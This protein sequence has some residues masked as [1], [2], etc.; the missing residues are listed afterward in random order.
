[1]EGAKENLALEFLQNL[2]KDSPYEG[3]V[4]LAGGAVRDELMGIDPKDF[5][6]LIWN[7]VES[8]LLG[9]QLVKWVIINEVLILVYRNSVRNLI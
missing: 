9:G 1:M 6:Q 2:I 3:I 8:V 7:L 4:Y 5:D